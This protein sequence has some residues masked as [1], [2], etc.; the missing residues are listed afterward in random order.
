MIKFYRKGFFFY[1]IMSKM[2]L[3]EENKKNNNQDE[4]E[5]L[6]NYFLNDD[7]LEFIDE[8]LLDLDFDLDD[9]LDINHLQ[10]Q[11]SN[12]E[13][14]K[15][16]Y[17]KEILDIKID[18]S[19]NNFK[20]YNFI[21]IKTNLFSKCD[22][23]NFFD[24]HNLT[25]KLI[26]EEINIENKKVTTFE[27][28]ISFTPQKDVLVY[29]ISGFYNFIEAL[30]EFFLDSFKEKHIFIHKMELYEKIMNIVLNYD[31]LKN[32]I[33]LFKVLPLSL[34][35]KLYN[36]SIVYIKDLINLVVKNYYQYELEEILNSLMN[37]IM[38]DP[39]I[40]LDDFLSTLKVKNK[41]IL[42]LRS[43]HTLEEIGKKYNCTRERI[44]Q[45]E[46]NALIKFQKYSSKNYLDES[47]KQYFSNYLFLDDYSS[48]NYSF[49]SYFT[50]KIFDL[51]ESSVLK[52]IFF[53]D[54]DAKEVLDF[55]LENMPDVLKVNEFNSYSKDIINALMELNQRYYFCIDEIQY[56]LKKYYTYNYGEIYANHKISKTYLFPIIV[57]ECF[58]E[59]IDIYDQNSLVLFKEKAIQKFNF[60]I[61]DSTERSISSILQKCLVLKDRGFYFY[62]ED[63]PIIEGKLREDIEKYILNNKSSVISYKEIFEVFYDELLSIEID[64]RYYLAAQLKKLNITNITFSRDYIYK[65]NYTSITETYLEVEKYITYSNKL[66]SREDIE[67]KFPAIKYSTFQNLLNNT[68]IVNMNGYF[69]TLKKLNIS[70]EEEN[71]MINQLY[72]ILDESKIFHAK[73]IFRK[74]KK[75]L[76]SFFNRNGIDHYLKFYYLINKL[77]PLDFTYNRPYISNL[78]VEMKTGIQQLKEMIVNKGI[79]S[80]SGDIKFYAQEL[81]YYIDSYLELVNENSDA[82]IFKDKQNVVSISRANIKEDELEN[83]DLIL[84]QFM[85]SASYKP[86]CSFNLFWKLPKL[87]VQWNEWVLSS[88]VNKYSDKYYISFS[89]KTLTESNPVLVRNDYDEEEIDY[90]SIKFVKNFEIE[91]DL[92]LF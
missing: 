60:D 58:P 47:I 64:N 44:R 26:N 14:K 84:D 29:R 78:N 80:I 54:A 2:V 24:L 23:I 45:I 75:Y 73:E 77:F 72:E 31:D 56:I 15:F 1:I 83:L 46:K 66:V 50:H 53:F 41:K 76:S 48:N 70:K 62:E 5:N 32:N 28:V 71:T 34:A 86:L 4:L 11:K 55:Y 30:Y 8:E 20:P 39:H 22:L 82:F 37:K 49:S 21:E 67:K 85:K 91:F 43:D 13:K 17:Q 6:T 16:V 10:E 61:N 40:L 52:N 65:G 12:E 25:Y 3:L 69:T 74:L 33:K 90:S 18:I 51:N 35:I 7:E 36:N 68:G 63:K 59:G 27:E 9:D 57:A 87:G 42:L 79:C 19:T 92:D 88:I 38:I 89:S 81:G